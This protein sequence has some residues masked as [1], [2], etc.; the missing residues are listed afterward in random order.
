GDRAGI[1]LAFGAAAFELIALVVSVGYLATRLGFTSAAI[2]ID[3]L[4][5][6]AAMRRSW[7]LTRGAGWRLYLS[8]LLV[9]TMVGLATAVLV[10]PVG[11]AIDIAGGLIFPNG[12][13]PEVG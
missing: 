3:G 13:T 9:W 7:Y 5:V 12:P 2:T 1:G 11:W 6:G 10:T 8:Q 4:G